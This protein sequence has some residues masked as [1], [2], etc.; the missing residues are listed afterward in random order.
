M[1]AGTNKASRTWLFNQIFFFRVS[2]ET[3]S[4]FPRSAVCIREGAILHQ[5]GS[6][7][8]RACSS[9]R[10]LSY[11]SNFWG[12]KGGREGGGDV[13]NIATRPRKMLRRILWRR[14]VSC[15]IRKEYPLMESWSIPPTLR[16]GVKHDPQA[17]AG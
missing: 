12:G 17:S 6:H 14:F 13:S 5:L 7:V 16:L 11:P 3:I 1:I 10:V 2:R 8:Y 9:F 4:S 15:N